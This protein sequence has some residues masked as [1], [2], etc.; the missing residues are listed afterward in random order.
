MD[1]R[2]DDATLDAVAARHGFNRAAV[3]TLW[4][5]LR[6][7][8]GRM[9]QFSHPELGGM[10]QWSNGGM[11]QIGAMFDHA[12]KARVAAACADLAAA[13]G[14]RVSTDPGEA[15]AVRDDAF[16]MERA[17]GQA[18]SARQQP[19]DRRTGSAT[20]TSP[21]RAASRSIATGRSRST[22]RA[23]IEFSACRKAR[24][25]DRTSP[26]R[27]TTR[28]STSKPWQSSRGAGSTKDEVTRGAAGV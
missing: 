18:H 26:S 12:L 22:T 20:P 1:D 10:G 25:A 19:R 16:G 17:G 21:M 27:P 13:A 11:L 6:R 4:D 9:A 15:A 14:D 23:A 8:G 7:G 28:R 24:A 3:A 2:G 5:A